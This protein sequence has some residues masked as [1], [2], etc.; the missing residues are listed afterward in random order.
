M[1]KC[2]GVVGRFDVFML[3]T[4]SA[5]PP[6]PT[7]MQLLELVTLEAALRYLLIDSLS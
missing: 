4:I 7:N 6:L 5:W 3:L 2:D 1:R